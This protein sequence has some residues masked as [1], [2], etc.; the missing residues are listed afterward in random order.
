[1]SFY[2][3]LSIRTQLFL[4][5]A[6]IAV[7]MLSIIAVT[8]MQMA[9]II[10]R[11]NER[12]TNDIIS[13]IRQTV[14][15]NKDVID[16]LMSNIAFDA[17]VQNFLTRPDIAEIYGTSKKVNRLFLNMSNL[18]EGILDIVVYG[19]Q[20]RWYDLYGGKKKIMPFVNAIMA[21]D[22]PY[23]FGMQ[24]FGD[25]YPSVNCY[26]IGMKIRSYQPGEQ[27]NAV[28]G[29][30]F[31]IL[32]PKA[33][34][35]Q[36]DGE[37]LSEVATESFLIDRGNKIMSSRDPQQV[38]LKLNA[39]IAEGQSADGARNVELNGRLYI[40]QTEDLPEIN[41]MIV[42]MIPKA[43]LMRDMVRIQRVEVML[44][45]AGA[46]IIL[47]LVMLIINNLLVPLKKLMSF[48]STIKRGDLNKLKKRILLRGYA[49]IT[50]MSTEFNNM[51]DQVDGLTRQ[52]LETNAMLYEAELTKKRS[53]LLF[54][55]SQIN[56][57]FLYNTLEMVKGMAA[58]A[59]AK[60]IREIARALGEIFRY[61]I[62][63]G[64]M[65]PLRAE[66]AI[67]RS[68]MQ[69]Q[70]LRFGDRFDVRY[71]LDEAAMSQPVP[72]MILQPIVENAV[73][74]G[75]ELK[76]E[77]GT[78]VI[79]TSMNAPGCLTVAVEDDGIGIEAPRLAEI[80]Q[81]IGRA[82]AGRT[83]QAPAAADEAGA[84]IGLANVHHRLQLTYGPSGGL[85][86]ESAPGMGTTIRLTMPIGGD[87]DVQRID[88]G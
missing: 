22:A 11:N 68:Y 65:V 9:G 36:E 6:V 5:V 15:A 71:E 61:S 57:H 52:L 32:D 60:D 39:I 46:V 10:T 2:R 34:I 33:L 7:V 79:R 44:L 30:L 55:R 20:S 56:P 3:M 73:F 48:I 54:L 67:V 43:E 42:S 25:T 58:V 74:H 76:E 53:E 23:Y 83:P 59:G 12:Y 14:H 27:F 17:D 38:G 24:N 28:I 70:Q 8:Y 37:Q 21:R 62:K 81:S 66:L 18:K 47:L 82:F 41:G 31:F 16:R 85:T 49:E 45:V 86:I 50:V 88:R 1:M 35:G 80:Q 29:T 77:P 72:K 87:L 84:S 13:Q 63:G 69:I 40:V 19:E 26:L 51:L 64:D 4:M 75:L 78:L